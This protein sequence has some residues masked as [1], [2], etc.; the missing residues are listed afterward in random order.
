MALAAL[1]AFTL[2]CTSGSSKDRGNDSGKDHDKGKE[3]ATAT[4]QQPDTKP[5]GP[6]Q[7][8][9]LR[10]PSAEPL[11]LNPVIQTQFD[12]VTHLIFEGLVGLNERAEPVPRL[13]SKWDL[14]DD[15]KTL[16][17]TLRSD[18]KWH[19]GKPFTAKDVDF[20]YKAIRDTRAPSL[21]KAYVADIETV[22]APD[23]HTVKVIYKEAYAPALMAWT[24]GILPQHLYGQGELLKSSYNRE[25][26]GSGPYKLVRWEP[27]QRML[28]RANREWWYKESDK[29]LPYIETIELLFGADNDSIEA[30]EKGNIDFIEILDVDQWATQAQTS[31][32]RE[33]F[34]V[35]DVAEPQFRAIAWNAKQKELA[36]KRVRQALTYA[37]NRG[38]VIDDVMFRSA[39]AISG[40]FFPTMYGADPSIAP[41]PFDLDKAVKLLDEA[42]YPVKKKGPRFSVE[43]I[44]L[45][46]QEFPA[47]HASIG[48]FRNDLS[49]IGVELKMTYLD[50]N[51]FFSR[52]LDG[53]YGAVYFNWLPDIADPDPYGLLHSEMIGAGSNY[54]FY[55][56]PDVDKLLEQARSTASRD[57]RKSLYHQL[58]R[59]L[60]E[61]MPYT[62]LYAPMAHYA[63]N[64]TLRG[65][66]PT[67]ISAQPRFPG[68]A[69]WWM[70]TGS[71][72][73]KSAPSKKP[74]P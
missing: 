10:M 60:H 29:P 15:G 13:A 68:M 1:L 33:R 27:G 43:V 12:R 39:Q 25:A 30:L 45:K 70:N 2:S 31:D 35:T 61:D 11:Y 6:R 46:S 9:H 47:T 41:L 20:T 28:L 71:A 23:D 57:E 14:S 26:V 42:G 24:F 72:A 8:G 51:Q 74:A 56:N 44:A 22:E 54:A 48:M 18:V 4:T 66:N 62:P 21:W 32:F 52:V 5:T 64:R 34:E 58:H 55:S 50:A 36:D 53:D 37:I 38:R 63:W 67:D 17:F 3:A 16:T 49:G 65:V 59:I 19:D 40:P 73:T 7:G 69:R